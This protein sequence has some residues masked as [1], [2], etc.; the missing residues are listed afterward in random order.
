M[1]A[2]LDYAAGKLR[3]RYSQEEV[4]MALAGCLR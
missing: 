4:A 2:Y 3:D 1:R